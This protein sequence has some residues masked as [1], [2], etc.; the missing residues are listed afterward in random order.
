MNDEQLI[1]L[2]LDGELDLDEAQE[3]EERLER[4]PELMA[5]VEEQLTL[6]AMLSRAHDFEAEGLELEGFTERVMAAIPVD[7]RYQVSA[8]PSRPSQEAELEGPLQRLSGWI[9]AH[10]TA[11]LVGAAVAAALMLSLQAPSAPSGRDAAG[12]SRST[13]LIKNAEPKQDGASSE[14]WHLDEEESDAGAAGED[15]PL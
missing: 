9:A 8:E 2:Y 6:S 3:L 1:T 11:L 10:I 12:A 4:E 14:A 13:L 5:M 15:E 7:E